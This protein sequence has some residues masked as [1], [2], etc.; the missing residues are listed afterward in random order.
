MSCISAFR[1]LER[2]ARIE[3]AHNGL[4]DRGLST[5]LSPQLAERTGFEPARQVSSSDRL[6]NDCLKP[7]SATSPEFGGRDRIRTCVLPR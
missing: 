6:A 5:W 2:A 1:E 7:D 3:L 4:E